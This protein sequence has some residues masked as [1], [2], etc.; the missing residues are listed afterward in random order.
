MAKNLVNM[1][2]NGGAIFPL[3]KFP[4][5]G[6]INPPI[7]VS[8]SNDPRLKAYNDSLDLYNY[9]NRMYN[10]L[11]KD[12][13]EGGLT[14][15]YLGMVLPRDSRFE[16]YKNDKIKPIG[17][18]KDTD[19]EDST[20]YTWLTPV[21]QQPT[22]SY[23][24][25]PSDI[26]KMK[27]IQ[28][29]FNTTQE[30]PQTRPYQ[31]SA[32]NLPASYMDSRGEVSDKPQTAPIYTEEQL[33]KMGYR[34]PQTMKQYKKGGTVDIFQLMDMPT[35][36]MYSFGGV[37]KD[38]GA[39][40]IGVGSGGLNTMTGGMTSPLTDKGID[41]YGHMTGSTAAE[42]RQQKSI[43]GYGRTAGAVTAGIVTGNVG[44]AIKEGA[45]GLGT[46]ISAGS[47][48]SQL[49]QDM[50]QIL[51]MAGYLGGYGFNMGGGPNASASAPL[52]PTKAYGGPVNSQI[53]IE[54]EK[55]EKLV[56]MDPNGNIKQIRNYQN[57]DFH[58]AD[59]TNNPKNFTMA[60]EGDVVLSNRLRP[61]A[62]ATK[63][64]E[65]SRSASKSPAYPSYSKLFDFAHSSG[66]DLLKKSIV[67]NQMQKS[68]VHQAKL[69]GVIRR[70]DGGS[71]VTSIGNFNPQ[72]TQSPYAPWF[73]AFGQPMMNIGKGIIDNFDAGNGSLADLQRMESSTPAEWNAYAT[74]AAQ[75]SPTKFDINIST[76]NKNTGKYLDNRSNFSKFA[77]YAT[78]LG[79][80]I[81]DA[82][83]KPFSMNSKGYMTKHISP[84]YM[85]GDTGRRDL[86]NAYTSAKAPLNSLAGKV[87][88]YDRYAEQLSKYNENLENQNV[89]I[90]NQFAQHNNQIDQA[91]NQMRFGIDQFNEQNKAAKRNAMRGYVN[92]LNTIG[93]NERNNSLQKRWLQAAYPNFNFNWGK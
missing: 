6:T 88:L 89:G 38:V 87:A 73:G 9:G 13:H 7:Y 57:F 69:G 60:Q 68:P 29:S 53:P 74:Q 71:T 84:K 54:V 1:F 45:S 15:K 8:D 67:S 17:L 49:A 4:Q 50:G 37:L 63:S 34:K 22:Q 32:A 93:Q 86:L 44:G 3:L 23:I 26:K 80:G 47:P 24:Y 51:P 42:M 76:E 75:T 78:T 27:S 11:S 16:Q 33:L 35:P 39:G 62:P 64:K 19:L 85:M 10:K 41:M 36:P 66:D 2:N 77:P 83:Q 25:K 59:G 40:V 21:Y 48:D 92:D 55:K 18:R 72:T 81:Y 90:G 61:N 43:Y 20:G 30:Q 46:G 58:N 79:M 65:L 56:R 91:N 12:L 52:V 14:P 70:Y 28:P 31:V 82:L 5:G